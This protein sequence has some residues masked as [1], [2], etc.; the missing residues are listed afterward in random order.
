MKQD[1]TNFIVAATIKFDKSRNP[2][3]LAE[4]LMRFLQSTILF[5]IRKE[6]YIIILFWHDFTHSIYYA[7][8]NSKVAQILTRKNHEVCLQSMFLCTVF[9]RADSKRRVWKGGF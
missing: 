4:D 5:Y 2:L 9:C 8:F 7:N 6:E 1:K 3:D